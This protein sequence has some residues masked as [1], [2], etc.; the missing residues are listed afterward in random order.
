[1]CPKPQVIRPYY[2]TR[3][4]RGARPLS[5]SSWWIGLSRDAFSRAVRE[6]QARMAASRLAAQITGIT[7]EYRRSTY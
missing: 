6:H 3:E 1:M 5:L 4:Q 7:V 2:L